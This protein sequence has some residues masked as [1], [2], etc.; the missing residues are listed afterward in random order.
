MKVATEKKNQMRYF[1]QGELGEMFKVPETGYKVSQTQRQLH[2]EHYN[3]RKVNELLQE[4]IEFLEGLG[5]AGVSHHD[6]LFT[7]EAEPLPPPGLEEED[8]KASWEPRNPMYAA[9]RSKAASKPEKYTWESSQAAGQGI[10]AAA[11]AGLQSR[12]AVNDNWLKVQFLRSKLERLYRT[13]DDKALISRLPDQG[14]GLEKKINDTQNELTEAEAIASSKENVATE[15]AVVDLSSER[16]RPKPL[17]FNNS[18]PAVVA[19]PL[20]PKMNP[21]MLSPSPVV[22][23][24]NAPKA[25]PVS[26]MPN[27]S[28]LSDS[29][30]SSTGSPAPTSRVDVDDMVNSLSALKLRLH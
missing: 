4:H 16:S 15:P 26:E 7:K 28:L 30:T 18:I 11:N 19:Q 14:A 20:P 25:T 9:P 22:R 24:P 12:N 21:V 13:L 3:Q 2:K 29:P 23:V 6:L 10:L 5:I 8:L 1:S 17:G 27:W